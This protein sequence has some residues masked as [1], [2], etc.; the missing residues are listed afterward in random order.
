MKVRSNVSSLVAGTLLLVSSIALAQQEVSPFAYSGP[1]GSQGQWT[2]AALSHANEVRQVITK[3]KDNPACNSLKA[4]I[5]GGLA[6]IDASLQEVDK[7]YS[8]E[9]E[10]GQTYAALP[11]EIIAL[12]SFGKESSLFKGNVLKQLFRK[13]VMESE[14][15]SKEVAGYEEN[16]KLYSASLMARKQR[17]H[18]AAM[19][20]LGIFNTTF[21]SM[22]DAEASC[23]DDAKG[24]TT[25]AGMI[26]ILSSFATSGD[27]G[28]NSQLAMAV[29]NLGQ[30]FGRDQKYIDAIR[31]LNDRE[32]ISS[33][34]CLMEVTTDGYCAALDAQYM[35][36]EVIN[37]QAARV[38]SYTNKNTGLTENRVV[39]MSLNFS[40]KLE[41]G[42]LAGYYILTRQVPVVTEWLSKVQYGITPQLPTEADFQVSVSTNVYEHYNTL[43]QIEGTFNYQKKLML[44]LGD[45]KAKQTYVLSMLENVGDSM[46]GDGGFSR[47][48]G[49]AENFFSKV[50]TL[51][52]IYFKLLG[53]NTPDSVL[54]SG[55]EAIQFSAQPKSWLRAKYR[56][57]PQFN[58][59]DKLAETIYE[60]MQS[61]FKGATSLAIAY[62]NKYFIVDKV[63]VVNDSLLGLDVS[64]RDA[65]VNIDRYLANLQSRVLED[66]KDPTWIASIIDTRRRIGRILSRYKDLRQYG[67][68]L[69]EHKKQTGTYKDLDD[70]KMSKE[71]R[72]IGDALLQ[73][74]Y[75]EFEVLTA[76]TGFLS[77]RMAGFV[78]QDYTIS[79]RNRD[80]FNQYIN[81]LMLATGYN[82]LNTMINMSQTEFSKVK[83][84]LN[85]SMNIYKKTIEALEPVVTNIF[86]RNIMDLKMMASGEEL[87]EADR[88]AMIYENERK[89]G[90]AQVP[91]ED[92]NSFVRGARGILNRVWMELTMK[93]KEVLGAP[94]V[95][96]KLMLPFEQ[97]GNKLMGVKGKIVISPV[98]EFDTAS[99]EMAKLCIQTLAF[100]NLRPFW[101][102]CQEAHLESPLLGNKNLDQASKQALDNYLSVYYVRKGYENIERNKPEI[103]KTDRARNYQA[104]ICALRDYHRRN[105][106][107]RVTSAMRMD[108]DTYENEFTKKIDDVMPE[109]PPLD[110][111]QSGKTKDE[112]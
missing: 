32:L 66:A 84:D 86:T 72:K 13:T 90:S 41:E 48:N 83:T 93:D 22:L 55:P 88:V 5:Q 21:S 16:N 62:Y 23:L 24:T 76:R 31:K 6:G 17:A 85:Q 43:K 50:S 111:K 10:V 108:G 34:S 9:G 40:K 96:E 112:K 11:Q 35:F 47:R 26:K 100:A 20:G 15:G 75:T 102:L 92:T 2:Q 81:D 53:I 42:P 60:N 69:L 105:E 68:T 46:L 79:L 65:L 59:P 18:R 3:L 97:I 51:N 91:S 29:Q 71:L 52:E 4:S 1:C 73:Q 101:S 70:E 28:L 61:L 56:N 74:V 77:K 63:Q 58:D 25:I 30:Y 82:S 107:A 27:Q 95:R 104:R 45:F 106:V 44:E 80:E 78:Y 89:M 14:L 109:A 99:G 33:M 67:V 7:A 110:A 94:S 12:R 36:Q 49:S 54:G 37:G 19:A 39:G 57:L 8:N 64:V 103:T 38:E 87:T 98:S